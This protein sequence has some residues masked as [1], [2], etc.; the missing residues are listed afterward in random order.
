VAIARAL[1][2]N[3]AILIFDE[4]TSSLDSAN[5]RA[6]QAQL[7]KAA[8][9]KTVLVVAHRLS[10]IVDAQEILV[11][12]EGRI[13]ERG[14][15]TELL[16]RDGLYARMWQ[17]QRSAHASRSASTADDQAAVAPT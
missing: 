9:G 10:T 11:M 4:A 2:K 6:I 1:L 17:L 14:T 8:Q 12:G 3:P 13:Q 16:A 5:E 15:H 7:E